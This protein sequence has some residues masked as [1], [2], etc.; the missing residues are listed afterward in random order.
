MLSKFHWEIVFQV[1]P[2]PMFIVDEAARI[3]EF[4]VAAGAFVGKNRLEI[5][6]GR[7]GDILGCVNGSKGPAGC[8]SSS[9]CQDCAVRNGVRVAN[10]GH[11]T[12]QVKAKLERVRGGKPEVDQILVTAT[13]FKGGRDQPL[14]LLILENISEVVKLRELLPVCVHCKKIRDDREYWHEVDVYF[15]QHLEIDFS[16]G[17]CPDCLERSLKQLKVGG[18]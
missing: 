3:A 7:L 17:L 11:I 12:H 6:G 13:P 10:N 2:L 14:V 9:E 4:N 5:V 15:T 1:T 8:G 16:H 18:K